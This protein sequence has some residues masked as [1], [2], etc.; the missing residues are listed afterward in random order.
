MERPQ[1]RDEIGEIVFKLA[2][3]VDIAGTPEVAVATNDWSVNRCAGI[4]ER[5]SEWMHATAVVRRAMNQYHHLRA[6]VINPIAELRAVTRSIRFHRRQVAEI[7]VGERIA[8][9]GQRRRLH[10]PIERQ[11]TPD[12]A[13]HL[14][15]TDE[16]QSILRFWSFAKVIPGH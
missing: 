1:H 9:R 7:N 10:G 13:K 2:D 11:H 8:D 15:K 3:I 6:A 5:L 14:D 12:C 4:A 16:R